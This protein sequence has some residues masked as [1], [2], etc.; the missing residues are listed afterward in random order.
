[1]TEH[2][3]GP[4]GPDPHGTGPARLVEHAQLA[5]GILA[6]RHRGDRESAAVLASTADPHEL[7]GGALLLVELLAGLYA[8]ACCQNPADCLSDLAVQ[9]EASLP[10]SFEA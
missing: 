1:M 8:E 5:A 3:C 7:L 2:T 6:A 4:A 9:L 10:R